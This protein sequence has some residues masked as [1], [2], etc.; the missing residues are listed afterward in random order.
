MNEIILNERQYAETAIEHGYVGN[1][2]YVTLSI[3]AKYYYH[4]EHIKHKNICKKLKAFLETSYPK[5]R[6]MKSDMDSA[7]DDIAKDLKN[8]RLYEIYGVPITKTE[9]KTISSIGNKALE[10]F[11]FTLLCLAKYNNLKNQNNND[12][13]VQDPSLI[14]K[15]SRANGNNI[16]DKC[17][18]YNGLYK[19]G[20]IELAKKNENTNVRVLFV[21]HTG[22]CEIFIDDFRELGNEYRLIRGE[23]YSRC[24]ECGRLFKDSKYKPRKFC[25]DCSGYIPMVTKRIVCESCGVEFTIPAKNN[26][27][28]M[29]NKCA[30]SKRKND[31]KIR[32]RKSREITA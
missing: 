26:R 13:V 11:A 27:T 6:L 28:T 1:N 31:A 19:L 20:L 4:I 23:S 8:K 7:V 14:F 22:E 3:L 29:C 12:W 9:L 16:Y 21:D 32:K 25:K 2:I 30:E 10:R 17:L 15:I 18:N 24:L 5:Y